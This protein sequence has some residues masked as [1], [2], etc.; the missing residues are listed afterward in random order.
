MHMC[1]VY[2]DGFDVIACRVLL[3]LCARATVHVMHAM[4]LHAQFNC[5]M[6]NCTTCSM[7]AQ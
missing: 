3:C 1:V 7:V 5:R 4:R 2:D 6:L